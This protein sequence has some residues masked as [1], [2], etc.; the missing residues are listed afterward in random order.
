MLFCLLE[1]DT[2]PF[3]VEVSSDTNIFSLKKSIRSEHNFRLLRG[4]D[5]VDLVLWKVSRFTSIQFAAETLLAAQQTPVR[6]TC[7]DSS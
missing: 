2:V 3:S 7:G 4:V 6:N 5:A 1:G